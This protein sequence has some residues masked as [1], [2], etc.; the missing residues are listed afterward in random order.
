MHRRPQQI[1]STVLMVR[2]ANFG[3]NPE[4][5]ESN[6]FQTSSGIDPDTIKGNALAEF[7][8]FAEQLRNAGIEVIVVEDTA[9][10]IKT[11]AVF[12]NNIFSTHE[13]GRAVLY[14][15]L[16][17]N[18]RL[19]R[20]NP[21][22]G[23]LSG[24]GITETVDLSG[25]EL[26]G[27]FLEGT[28]SMVLDRENGIV[29][30]CTSPRTHPDI[31]SEFAKLFGC[32]PA[33]FEAVDQGGKAIYHTNVMMALG[34]EFVVICLDAI[35]DERQRNL[36][37][38]LLSETGKE[39]IEISLA[40]ME[41][42]AGNM[43]QLRNSKGERFIVL[44]TTAYNSISEAQIKSLEKHGKL[45]PADIPAIETC[46]GGSVRCMLAEVFLTR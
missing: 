7:D 44:S 15:M 12:P 37:L 26:E 36:L 38:N 40:Q 46:G 32:H 6:A 5:A 33:M 35:P 29:Y 18:R 1:A 31:V 28:G 22:M 21:I 8:G 9:V 14:P 27:R 13:D 43:L 45:I 24:Y 23:A 34:E 3:F 20:Q 17:K 19:E 42:F 16:S 30:A 11:D 25:H 2:P 10:P 4:T 41:R 39:I